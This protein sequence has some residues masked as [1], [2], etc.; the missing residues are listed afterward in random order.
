MLSPLSSN[1]LDK[2]QSLIQ[3]NIQRISSGKAINSAADNPAGLVIA[4][5]MTSQLGGGRVKR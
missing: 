2:T 3:L 5:A 4:E 1:S